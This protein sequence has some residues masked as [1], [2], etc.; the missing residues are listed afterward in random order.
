[1]A[2]P[3]G[4]SVGPEFVGTVKGV[5]ATN[6]RWLRGCLPEFLGTMNLVVAI[7]TPQEVVVKK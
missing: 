3:M 7:G 2:K 1:M 4:W 5:F 6:Y